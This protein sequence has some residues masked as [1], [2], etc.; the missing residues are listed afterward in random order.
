[1]RIESEMDESE[2]DES[3][4]GVPVVLDDVKDYP[5]F[6][7]T[8]FSYFVV[9]CDEP[10]PGWTLMLAQARIPFLMLG[11]SGVVVSPPSGRPRFEGADDFD[12]LFES[13]ES[14]DH[15]YVDLNDVWLPN[16]CFEPARLQRSNVFRIGRALFATALSYRGSLIETGRFVALARDMRREI[17]FSPNE[18]EAFRAWSRNQIQAAHSQYHARSDVLEYEPDPRFPEKDE[19]S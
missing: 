12:D 7:M 1:M 2:M 13:I 8:R 9:E 3:E 18:S 19:K 5:D 10:T 11:L 6:A 16:D 17:E 14:H 4:I 15:V